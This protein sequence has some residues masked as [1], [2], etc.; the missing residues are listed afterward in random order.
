[1]PAPILCFQKYNVFVCG[2][3]ADVADPCQFA[4]IQLPVFESGIVAEEDWRVFCQYST[5][6]GKRKAVFFQFLLNFGGRYDTIISPHKS[7]QAFPI[8]NVFLLFGKN[9]FSALRSL[10]EGEGFVWQQMEAMCFSVCSSIWGYTLFYFIER[11][12]RQ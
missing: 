2:G 7:I 6:K 10:L 4:D 3:S 8:G 12:N 11:R 1:M 9:A 5:P